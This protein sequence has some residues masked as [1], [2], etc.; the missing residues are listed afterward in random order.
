M[1]LAALRFAT[2][3]I[4]FIQIGQCISNETLKTI[5]PFYI[6]SSMAGEVKDPH[7]G[8]GGC[9]LSWTPAKTTDL[10]VLAAKRDKTN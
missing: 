10:Q 8:G 6:V 4:P 5:G 3:A 7:I 9:K 1:M 2:L